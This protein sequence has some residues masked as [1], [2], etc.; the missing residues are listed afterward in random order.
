MSSLSDSVQFVYKKQRY[1]LNKVPFRILYVTT[2]SL[3]FSVYVRNCE[4]NWSYF[5][6]QSHFSVVV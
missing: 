5:L 4:I 1:L 6:L 3:R 2:R